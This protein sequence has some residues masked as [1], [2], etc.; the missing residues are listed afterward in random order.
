MTIVIK[1]S[2]VMPAFFM[3]ELLAV[4]AGVFYLKRALFDIFS[5]NPM[6][7]LV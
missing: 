6:Q 4:V 5:T 7:A 2:R 1:P 3:P